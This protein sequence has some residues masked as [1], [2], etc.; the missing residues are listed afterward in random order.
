MACGRACPTVSKDTGE[1]VMKTQLL[2]TTALAAAGVA[3]AASG[4]ALAQKKAGKPVLTLGGYQ[5][6][7]AGVATN[8]DRSVGDRVAGMS[9]KTARSTSRA[10]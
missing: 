4:T 2:T 10:W 8:N 7:I 1:V 9:S 3:V 6:G 5:E